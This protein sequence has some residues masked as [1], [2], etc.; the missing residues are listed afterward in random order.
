MGG[1]NDGF[2]SE[3]I[4]D[5]AFR[6]LLLLQIATDDTM[7]WCWGDAGA[8]Y[9]WIRFTY[10]H[11]GQRHYTR[12]NRPD[13]WQHPATPHAQLYS[14]VFRGDHRWF[15]AARAAVVPSLV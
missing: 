3:P 5:S 2:Q 6:D 4:E 1:Y 9:F 10:S 15:S 7:D 13:R 14:C 8:H 12:A 11:T